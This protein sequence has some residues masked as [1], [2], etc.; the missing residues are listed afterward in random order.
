MMMKVNDL[1]EKTLTSP[2]T[3][4]L[5]SPRIKKVRPFI[6]SRIPQS[7]INYHAGK[8]DC[9]VRK[10]SFFRHDK[11]LS[12]KDMKTLSL[13]ILTSSLEILISCL[14]VK[15]SCL[16]VEFF[17]EEC[18]ISFQG[19]NGIKKGYMALLIYSLKTYAPR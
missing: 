15:T 1:R 7:I 19:K 6:I 3:F 14:E 9:P 12:R 17:Q 16:E 18:I 4:L 8:I 11:K 5:N 10:S 13:E 2:K